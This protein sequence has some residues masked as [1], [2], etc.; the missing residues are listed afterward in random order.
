LAVILA[1]VGLAAGVTHFFKHEAIMAAPEQ[2]Q[3]GYFEFQVRLEEKL[4]ANNE[5]RP[6]FLHNT[7]QRHMIALGIL[8]AAA[9]AF[10]LSF[11]TIERVTGALLRDTLALGSASLGYAMVL[12]PL[13]ALSSPWK[14][15]FA[16]IA[17]A[18]MFLSLW[19]F[20]RFAATYPRT[21]VAGQLDTGKWEW[22]WTRIA[23]RRKEE[24]ISW[25]R[26]IIRDLAR[27][28]P[29]HL[30]R[31]LD[32]PKARD[33]DMPSAFLVDAAL[34]RA[35]Q[36]KIWLVALCAIPAVAEM[37]WS[38]ASAP[39]QTTGL[40]FQMIWWVLIPAMLY[41]PL[42]MGYWQHNYVHADAHERRSIR[43]WL[44]S[45]Y[46]SV[47]L[48]FTASI[49]TMTYGLVVGFFSQSETWAVIF[50]GMI[51]WL[52]PGAWFMLLIAIA[53][54]IFLRGAVEPS[55]VLSRAVLY[56]LIIILMT[57]TF[58][59]IE[60]ILQVQLVA[61][62]D[63]PDQVGIVVTGTL[64]AFVLGPLRNRVEGSISNWVAKVLPDE[65]P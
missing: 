21:V 28:D 34:H 57:V 54:S 11:R 50:A 12:H 45:I 35:V 33:R 3:V 9:I 15:L 60:S 17:V 61:T 64:V 59:I 1:T 20:G 47:V 5:P 36:G 41:Y 13:W 40:I 38:S 44:M 26:A 19:M 2:A 14:E 18:A 16:A 55:L 48:Y 62:F 4:S 63:L 53:A 52:L 30:S 32:A 29:R 37:M 49:A 42:C 10:A 25:S 56:G 46:L 24:G 22:E 7:A 51:Y 6:A 58:V 43:W 39:T 23:R 8:L 31:F 27:L 65:M